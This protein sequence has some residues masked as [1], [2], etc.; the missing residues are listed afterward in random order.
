MTERSKDKQ[1]RQVAKKVYDTV[2]QEL[3]SIQ[4]K[5]G[6]SFEEAFISKFFQT[7][8]TDPNSLAARRLGNLLIPQ[9]LQVLD[10]SD[11][12]SL[13]ENTDFVLFRISKLFFDKQR[14]LLMDS[15][16][17]RKL[18]A[19]CSRRAGKT[20]LNAGLVCAFAATPNTP[21]FYY[22][23]TFSNAIQQLFDQVIDIADKVGL[24]ISKASKNTGI[25]EFA[26][27]SVVQFA[28]NNDKGS[29]DT[30]RG[31]KAK[32]VIIDEVGHQ[33]NLDMLLEALLPIMAD[34][35]DSTLVLTG[36][37]SRYKKHESTRIWEE[38]K[39]FKKY[40]WT[41]YDNPHMPNPDQLIKDS[42]ST[43][44]LDINSPFI[45]REFYGEFV[46]DTEALI[47]KSPVFYS[48][49]DNFK[50]TNITIGIDYGTS[51]YNAIVSLA[52]NKDTKQARVL[53]QEKFNHAGAD[54]I[55]Q[56][57]SKI[58]NASK[59]LFPYI[60][61]INIYADTSDESIT[62]DMRVRY[63]LPAFNAYKLDKDYALQRLA[64]E[65]NTGRLQIKDKNSPLADEFEKTLYQRDIDDMV[66]PVMDD[67]VYH[68]DAIMAL[69]YASRKMLHDYDYD[70][71]YK[72]NAYYNDVLDKTITIGSA[73]VGESV[74]GEVG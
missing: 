31:F 41:L 68:A 61:E 18:M 32:L 54:E 73:E 24:K 53:F 47:F 20:A 67:K 27:G 37:P 25:I 71:K 2:K 56:R 15:F 36:T 62:K 23:K 9:N 19:I 29:I 63:K 60:K 6:K 48:S 69:L 50:P 21:I 4:K 58:Y 17:N 33:A 12:E 49:L 16:H 40:H 45:R 22:N 3:L 70:V 5:T 72:E 65:V 43:M 44:G 38:D 14:E 74:G 46:W 30:I 55:C 35:S 57:A 52:Y 10:A 26:N 11:S 64:A 13:R 51:A 1:S 34:F 59:S 7:A 28:G 66:I 39:S 8:L 42:C